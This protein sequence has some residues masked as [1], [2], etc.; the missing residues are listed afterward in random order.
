[1]TSRHLTAARAHGVVRAR[2][3]RQILVRAGH[4]NRGVGATV[5]THTTAVIY[6][7][8][9][10]SSR[11][12]CPDPRAGERA[13]A[14]LMQWWISRSTRYGPSRISCTVAVVQAIEIAWRSGWGLFREERREC[15]TCDGC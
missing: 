9:T 4:A 14:C 12:P 13:F 1:M 8:D 3:S 2:L 10:P 15:C 5:R 7:A 6:C 11:R